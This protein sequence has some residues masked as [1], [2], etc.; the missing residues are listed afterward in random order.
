MQDMDALAAVL[1]KAGAMPPA[2]LA[3]ME[4]AL[5]AEDLDGEYQ[6]RKTCAPQSPLSLPSLPTDSM[7]T[8]LCRHC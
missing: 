2:L 3:A 8:R 7:H 4:A 6:V 5:A 1:A